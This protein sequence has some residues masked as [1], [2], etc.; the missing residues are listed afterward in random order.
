MR[1]GSSLDQSFRNIG[2]VPDRQMFAILE[3][4]K[5]LTTPS[6]AATKP[7]ASKP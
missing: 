4:V 7:D 6:G 3:K 2:R 1:E 5:Q